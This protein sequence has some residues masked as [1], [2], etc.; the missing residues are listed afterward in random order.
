MSGGSKVHRTQD[1]V[2]Q[3]IAVLRRNRERLLDLA[4][5]RVVIH[6]PPDE[7]HRDV[8]LEVMGTKLR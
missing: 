3:A 2:E 6:L 1:I 7:T 5:C 4:P 8:V